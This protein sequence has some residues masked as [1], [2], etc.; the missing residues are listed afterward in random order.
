MGKCPPDPRR[1]KPTNGT[2]VPASLTWWQSA[3]LF[4]QVRVTLPGPSG[5]LIHD[6]IAPL[7]LPR[8]CPASAHLHADDAHS[9]HPNLPSLMTQRK[10]P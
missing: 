6:C 7:T 8:T 1:C 3:S 5:R 2:A 4:S 9:S 10:T